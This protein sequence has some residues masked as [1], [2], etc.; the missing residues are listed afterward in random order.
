MYHEVESI[1]V[2]T[3]GFHSL[4]DGQPPFVVFDDHHE[5]KDIRITRDSSFWKGKYKG[6][7]VQGEA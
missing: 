7:D 5:V 6:K 2:V 3:G 4:E 1:K